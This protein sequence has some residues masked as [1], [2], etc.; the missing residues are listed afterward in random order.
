[1]KWIELIKKQS[2]RLQD[3]NDT[4]QLEEVF[5]LACDTTTL[6]STIEALK[7]SLEFYAKTYNT[8]AE[9]YRRA[10][11]DKGATARDILAKLDGGPI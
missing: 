2:D 9:E 11:M 8:N 5:A 6:I 4:M 10:L 3:V 7:K 1:M